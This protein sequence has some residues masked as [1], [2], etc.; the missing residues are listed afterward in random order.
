MHQSKFA[1]SKGQAREMWMH[2]GHPPQLP[3]FSFLFS[4]AFLFSLGLPAALAAHNYP[5]T[6]IT[7]TAMFAM[8]WA[9][10]LAEMC[11]VRSFGCD[12]RL[13]LKPSQHLIQV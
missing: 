7:A 6:T 12:G 3:S 1:D 9:H 2:R 5:A 10:Q 11:L 4:P 8:N 13:C